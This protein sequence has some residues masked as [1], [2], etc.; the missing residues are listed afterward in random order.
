MVEASFTASKVF[1]F[2]KITIVKQKLMHS[3]ICSQTKCKYLLHLNC[4]QVM[5]AASS[6]AVTDLKAI[7]VGRWEMGD[8]GPCAPGADG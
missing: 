4:L 6:P 1:P 5:D 7:K 3:Y 2:S 8:N